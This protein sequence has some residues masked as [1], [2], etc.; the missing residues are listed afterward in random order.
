MTFLRNIY[1]FEPNVKAVI[2]FLRILGVKVNPTTVN[3]TLQN[4]PEWPSLLCISDSLTTWKV[5]NG[6]GKIDPKDIDKIPTPFV[7][8]TYDREAPLFIVTEVSDST[9]S[10]LHQGY[11][12]LKK[13]PKEGFIT[14]W[15]GV[16]LL[17]EPN[18][19]SGELEYQSKR[20]KAIIDSLLPILAIVLIVVGTILWLT[21]LKAPWQAIDG[22]GIYIQYF[23]LLFGVFISSLL[24]WYELDK[25]NP[26]LQK[27]CSGIV[28]GNCNA[29]LSSKQAKVFFW[30]SWSEVGFFHFAGGIIMLLFSGNLNASLT[31]LLLIN[32]LALP[33]TIFSVYYQWRVARQW[34]VLCL[35]IQALLLLAAINSLIYFTAIRYTYTVSFFV[36]A[37]ASYLLPVLSWYTLKPCFKDVQEAKTTKRS[38]SRLKFNTEIF[39][40]LLK[41]QPEISIVPEGLGIDL[42]NP[43]AINT[44]IKVCNP[45]CGPCA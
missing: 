33:Y 28:K 29:I 13:E 38:Y 4:H 18:V 19:L 3:E 42:G 45:Y 32:L 12:N 39:D 6:A 9:V 30:L 14:K 44:L 16:Y 7:A 17:A 40:T 2:R 15:D 20:Q 34:C 36:S 24:L 10:G 23:V 8:K 43:L 25:T 41:K 35:A 26:L 22:L 21:K 5:P 27:V 31:L 11:S 37:F 1:P